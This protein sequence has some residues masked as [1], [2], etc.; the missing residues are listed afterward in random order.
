MITFIKNKA[1]NLISDKKFSDILTGSTWALG[2]QVVATIISMVT[3]VIIARFYGAEILGIVA[4]INTFLMLTTIFTVLGTNTSILRLI[5]E[6]KEKYSATSAFKVYRKTQ[7]FVA[8][9]SLFTGAI[10]FFSA[11]FIAGTIFSNPALKF[12][13]S[14]AAGF[15]LFKSLM[16]LNT[17][18]VR[19]LYLNQ[20]FALMNVLPSLTK[21]I[22]L[23]LLTI[24]LF[25]D[26]NPIYA[27]FA[28]IGV[29]AIL[30]VWIMDRA[31]RKEI[32]PNDL[33]KEIGIN[34]ILSISMP[35]LM[36]ATMV[37]VTNQTG[38]LVLGIFRSEAEVGY[39]SVAVKFATLTAF[40]LRA[41]IT[42]SGPKFSGLYYTGKID[43]LFYVARKTSKLLFY[44][45]VPIMVIL[46]LTGKFVIEFL[47]GKDFVVA[48]WA[49]A[50]L[51]I[52]NFITTT[53]GPV[54][55][56]MNM[57]DNHK[58]FRNIK[59]ISAISTIGLCFL[60]IPV[61]G[62]YGAAFAGSFS[63]SLWTIMS[64]IFIK[65]KFGKT[66]GYLPFL[67]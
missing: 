13:F 48:Y 34:K 49:M 26:S 42:V 21:L 27:M 10:L 7:Y 57:T 8:I 31:F 55:M 23:I 64:I 28:S 51:M 33:V 18:A 47:Y 59:I 32:Q 3:S 6:H 63:L 24:F 9:L 19:G 4:M 5:P 22:V 17:Q 43:E 1:V 58:P 37:Y 45:T 14:L 53:G 46:V 67:N 56:F 2:A 39:Y 35:M 29:T 11:E 38:V 62:I 61:W 52:G 15:I 25:N 44:T 16:I 40:L 65:K 36:T 20:Q 12:Y 54:A 41:V 50:I 66:I 60:L 30:G